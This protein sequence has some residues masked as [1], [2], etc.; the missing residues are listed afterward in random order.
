M[1]DSLSSGAQSRKVR[2][3]PLG[4]R[5]EGE[6]MIGRTLR[7]SLTLA[8][9]AVVTLA[10]AP[11]SE[12]A[13]EGLAAEALSPRSRLE[14]NLRTLTDDIGGR[15]TGSAACERAVA[16]GV[17]AFRKAGV[18]SVGLEGY[19]APAKWEG[20]SAAASLVVPEKFPVRVVSF[21]LAPSTGGA[22]EAPLVD[23]GDGRRAD[24]ARLSGA[25]HGAV[26]LVRSNPM[27]S[28]DDLFA[29]YMAAPETMQSA[30]DAGAAAVRPALPTHG[31]LGTDRAHPDGPGGARRRPASLAAPRPRRAGKD[32]AGSSQ[33]RRRFLR[34]EERRRG[35]PGRVAGR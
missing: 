16:W 9:L 6:T 28:F 24:F 12:R 5:E 20:E 22:M 21:A 35:D 14:E 27:R 18:D 13:A 34:G 29:E 1:G 2:R 17:E 30:V 15:V 19:S 25:A 11:P 3:I 26:V 23:G 10:A 31:H 7:R 4:M 8:A 33:P 32:L